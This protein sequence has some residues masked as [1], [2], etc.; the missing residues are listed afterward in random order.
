MQATETSPDRSGTQLNC[1]GGVKERKWKRMA[2]Q[3][4]GR[5]R[6]LACGAVRE[7]AQWGSEGV[8]GASGPDCTCQK[9][10]GGKAA[11]AKPYRDISK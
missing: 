3:G 9:I 4:G 11:R 1:R 2:E 6:W 7:G 10:W 5:V 8:G